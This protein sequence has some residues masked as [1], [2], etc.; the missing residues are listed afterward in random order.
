MKH[1][2]KRVLAAT[3]I[4]VVAAVVTTVTRGHR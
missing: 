1:H 3:G 2:R 4:A